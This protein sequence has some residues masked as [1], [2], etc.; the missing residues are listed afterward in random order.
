MEETNFL[1]VI[2]FLILGKTWGSESLSW[3][4]VGL[5]I[6]RPRFRYPAGAAG[7]FSPPELTLCAASYSV[8]VPP[9]VLPQWHLKH[10]GHSATNAGGRLELNTHT[11]LTLRNRSGMTM[12]S[13]HS[14]GTCQETSSHATRQGMLVHSHL[15]LVSYCGKILA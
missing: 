11:P 9:P 3:W 13:R 1:S 4:T 15:S 8:S 5:V 6:G 14:M 10:P 7:E 2:F 12:L